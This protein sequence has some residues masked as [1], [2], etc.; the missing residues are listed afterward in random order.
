MSTYCYSLSGF[1]RIGPYQALQ[2]SP[3]HTDISGAYASIKLWLLLVPHAAAQR[4]HSTDAFG[5][6]RQE[7]LPTGTEELL[8]SKMIWNEL[9]P[10]FER[11]M[12]V[13][14][15]DTHTGNVTVSV[16]NAI[17]P[18]PLTSPHRHCPRRSGPP[19]Q[20]CCCSCANH[21]SLFSTQSPNWRLSNVCGVAC[22]ANP[23]WVFA[24]SVVRT[25]LTRYLQ[26]MRLARSINEPLPDLPLDFFV[27][28]VV[29]ELRAEEK[30]LA[31]HRQDTFPERIRRLAS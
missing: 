29:T 1:Q 9:W 3:L 30:L 17:K 21:D 19:S 24:A 10:P 6:N 23:R 14:E 13:L 5:G 8:T 16:S 27:N 12:T 11:I 2:N 25:I 22:E 15:A 31:A 7:G 28:Q 26:L 4:R 18:H 20:T